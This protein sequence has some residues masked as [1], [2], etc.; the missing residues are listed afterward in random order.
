MRIVGIH[1]K[2]FKSIEELELSDI[3]DVLILVG[4][5]NA[6]KSVVLDAVRAVT[7]DYVLSDRDFNNTTGNISIALKIEISE[8]DLKLLCQKGKVSS[9]KHFDLW[10]KDFSN[11]LPSYKD[12][13]LSF[14]YVY[15][16]DGKE[17]FK[18]GVKKNN[19]FIKQVLP[20]I[21][22]VDHERR[23]SSIQEDLIMLQGGTDYSDLMENVCIFDKHRSCNQCFN[24]IG[25]I[26][27]KKPEQ[28]NLS[29][30][31]RLMQYKLFNINLAK[32]ESK[33][34]ENFTRNGGKGEVIHY[35]IDFDAEKLM[36]INTVIRNYTR[37]VEGEISGLSDGLNSIYILS[38]LET[39]AEIGSDVPY[40]ILIE[41]PEIY[42]HPQLQ[43]VA[44]EIL[45]KLSKKNQV[46]FSTHAPQM[47][48]N[49]MTKQIKQVVVDNNNNTV[50][51]EETDIDDILD[52]LGYAAN[53]LM[54]VN[55]VFIVEGKQ[56]RSRLPLLLEKYYSEVV[57]SD[58]K[59]KR[60]AI[61]ATNSCTNIKTYA[62]LK[63]I[64]T[65]YL[66]DGFLMI[67][68]GD[69]K[70][71]DK[72]KNQLTNYYRERAKQDAGNLPRVTDRNVLILKYY[73]FENYFL[74]PEIMAKI[75][76]VKSVDAFYDKLF[77]K[78]QEYLYKLSSTK[79][80]LDKLGITIETKEDIIKNMENIRIYVR[81]HNLYD[82]F[83]GRYK[84]EKENAILKAYIDAA[85]K[86]NFKD[87]FE[88]IDNFIYFTNRR[89]HDDE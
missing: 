49:F 11:K 72:L 53:D 14:E 44:S 59:L 83:Y 80:M 56:D 13:V 52:D 84:G 78:Y 43:K 75:G 34:N 23:K 39:Y 63:Y 76:V 66:K 46:I 87:I 9:F 35:E 4:R 67:R 19:T 16:R 12:G 64:N 48:F 45:Y 69:G 54:N 29:E 55:F 10:Y 79:K 6:G 50:I 32:F 70:D 81:G 7:G 57:D 88:A 28:L 21:Y 42:L 18:D 31:A 33:L 3:E 24:C 60:I 86:D 73:S 58:G 74:D 47:L 65:L 37:K 27:K 40:I 71:A 15:S 82:I 26:Y 30:T 17:K 5:N 25:M 41:D 8:K 1:I 20:K 2:N 85:P 77:S 62:N 38:L 51:S 89:N 36:H 61:I 68:D 22:Y